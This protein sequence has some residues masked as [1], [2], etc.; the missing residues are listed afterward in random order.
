MMK[1]LKEAKD[2]KMDKKRR[3]DE[4]L[5]Q[6]KGEEEDEFIDDVSAMRQA[7]RESMQSQHEWHRMEEFRRSTGGWCNIYEEGRSSSH[8]SVGGYSGER[9]IPSESEF[10]LRGTIPELVKSKS[11][12][13]PKVRESILKT[14]RK[15]M[16]EAMSKIFHI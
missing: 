9:S 6:L 5:S 16:G 7:T 14:L 12:G 11:L 1:L 8:G 3:T 15:K 2:K 13:Q 10:N 4:F